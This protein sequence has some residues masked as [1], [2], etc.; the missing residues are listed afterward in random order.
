MI[1]S[2]VTVCLV[3]EARSGPF[4]FHDDLLGACS[5]AHALGFDAIE[6]FPPSGKDVSLSTVKQAVES[7]RL[8]LAAVGSGAG[9]V[10]HKLS[11]TH[12]DET[13]RSHARSFALG[14]INFAGYLN[15]PVIIGSMQGRAGDGA[16]REQALDWLAAELR[17]LSARAEGHGQCL[18][19]EPLNRYETNLFNRLSDAGAF[20]D[21]RG[22][23]SVKLLADLFHMNLEEADLAAALRANGPKIG[24]VHFADSNRRAMGCGH[25]AIGPIAAAL[26]DIGFD[27]CV[28]A[29]VFPVPDSHAAARQTIASFEHFFRRSPPAPTPTDSTPSPLSPC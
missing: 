26:N 18:L 9:W 5:S 8:A 25:T 27:G 28:S 15:A 23:E 13:V 22:L 12:A 24:H 14:L 16:S 6:L 1:R 7:H 20:L 11:L 21:E 2:A 3:P 10:R 4:V 29:E 19:Y 17:E